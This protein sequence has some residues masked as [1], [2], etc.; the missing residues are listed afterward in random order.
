[1]PT[2]KITI[3]YDG[4]NYVGWQVQPNGPSIQEKLQQALFKITEEKTV[5]V[6][7]GRTDAGVHAWGQVASFETAS[8]LSPEKLLRALNAQ[9]PYDITVISIERA[10]DDFHAIRNAKKK[11]YRYF[12]QDG[13]ILDPFGLRYAWFVPFEMDEQAMHRAGQVLIGEHDFTSFAAKKT[14]TKTNIRHIYGLTVTRETTPLLSRIVL[15]VEANGFLYNMVRNIAGALQP[16]GTG[17]QSESWLG[18]LLALKNREHP[19]MTAPPQ[20]LFMVDVTY[21]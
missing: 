4:T 3:A 5:V 1:M 15:E 7:S 13:R 17:R 12:F 10:P 21:D 2:F 8:T 18:E 9:T 14:Q 20:G 11:R 19:G 6:G 16:V